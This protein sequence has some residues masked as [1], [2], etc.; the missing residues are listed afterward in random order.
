MAAPAA[1]AAAPQYRPP[2]VTRPL[3]PFA[4]AAGA[5]TKKR[6]RDGEDAEDAGEGAAA[7]AGAG[8]A[9]GGGLLGAL[10]ALRSP[11]P[12]GTG[13]AKKA[14]TGAVMKPALSRD[15]SFSVKGVILL[16]NAASFRPSG[17][18]SF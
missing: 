10:Q 4:L 14:A 12:A 15:S 11:P 18:L 3:N 13:A 1:A 6:G 5:S 2:A 7:D 8:K 16:R 17:C 9:V